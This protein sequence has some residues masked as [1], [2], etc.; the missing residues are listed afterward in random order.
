MATYETMTGNG[1][2]S[3]DFVDVA[4]ITL[5]NV[6]EICMKYL[7]IYSTVYRYSINKV[8]H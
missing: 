5:T 1:T 8:S 7:N 6:S 2:R 4:V 3:D